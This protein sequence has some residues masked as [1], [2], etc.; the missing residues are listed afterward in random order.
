MFNHLKKLKDIMTI[1]TIFLQCTTEIK[2]CQAASNKLS[3]YYSKT[4]NS[5][6]TMY[7]LV[8]ILDLTQKLSL[9]KA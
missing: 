9:Y 5:N 1:N 3:K 4:E 7:N 2:A 6:E 8:N